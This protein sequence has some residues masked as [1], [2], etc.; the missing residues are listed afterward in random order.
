MESGK[1]TSKSF[2]GFHRDDH[3]IPASL[4]RGPHRGHR[5]GLPGKLRA[6][7]GRPIAVP[8]LSQTRSGSRGR[9][10]RLADSWA[11][12]ND[13]FSVYLPTSNPTAAIAALR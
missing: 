8:A 13:Q 11:Q 10:A 1:T 7:I 3:E 12:P 6:L 9:R 5:Q 4:G 2:T